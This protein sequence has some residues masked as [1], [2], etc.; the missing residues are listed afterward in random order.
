M[1]ELTDKR[2]QLA[3]TVSFRNILTKISG[4]EGNHLTDLASHDPKTNAGSM[5]TFALSGL[6]QYKSKSV[7][8]IGSDST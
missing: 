2:M 3:R 4:L 7:C 1:T 6:V 5:C 8:P